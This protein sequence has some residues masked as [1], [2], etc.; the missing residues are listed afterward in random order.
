[1]FSVLTH[2]EA[3]PRST[4]LY[5]SIANRVYDPIYSSQLII[6]SRRIVSYGCKERLQPLS[7]NRIVDFTWQTPI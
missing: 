6:L 2:N 7:H 3:I 1:M 5:I 4:N